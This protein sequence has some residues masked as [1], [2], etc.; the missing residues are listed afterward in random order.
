MHVSYLVPELPFIPDT[1]FKTAFFGSVDELSDAGFDF[2]QSASTESATQKKKRFSDEPETTHITV[3]EDHVPKVRYLEIASEDRA[4][5][6]TVC[7]A[8]RRHL[9]TVD[10]DELVRRVRE[11]G[12]TDSLVFFTIAYSAPAVYRQQTFEVVVDGLLSE[13]AEV[14]QHAAAAAGLLGWV[15]LVDPLKAAERKER[16]GLAK[17]AMQDALRAFGVEM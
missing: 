16:P 1:D 10:H 9:P 12:P 2:V 4:V 5:V 3:V 15:E 7:S 11:E 17:K 6:D 13:L 8:L 14:R